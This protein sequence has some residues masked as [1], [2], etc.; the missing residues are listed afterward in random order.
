MVWSNMY[1][2]YF[3]PVDVSTP[4]GELTRK[5]FALAVDKS[6]RKCLREI[7]EYDIS[8][9]INSF[10]P[11]CDMSVILN[12]LDAG[13]IPKGFDDRHCV[14][15]TMMPHDIVDALSSLRTFRTQFADL[16]DRVQA[17]FGYD[18]D[19]FINALINDQLPDAMFA[20]DNTAVDTADNTAVSTADNDM[21]V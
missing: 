12:K 21:E 13:L 17:M 16:D 2:A 7:R 5:E 18:A 14:D 11:G 1:D 9:Y 15:L 8:D 4:S 10:A 19:A 20:T 6:G 3:N